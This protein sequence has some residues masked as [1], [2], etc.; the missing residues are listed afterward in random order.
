MSLWLRNNND[1]QYSLWKIGDQ[2]LRG[3]MW[4]GQLSSRSTKGELWVDFPKNG[5]IITGEGHQ[6]EQSMTETRTS[7]AHYPN[8]DYKFK[9]VETCST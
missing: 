2:V 3:S 4:S 5:I 1:L 6:R 7:I 9:K 8:R